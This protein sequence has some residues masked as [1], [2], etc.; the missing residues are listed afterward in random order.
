MFY[1]FLNKDDIKEITNKTKK[2]KK[3]TLAISTAA[4]AIPVNPKTAAMIAIN[5]KMIVHLSIY[6][7]LS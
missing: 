7:L 4:P 1:R 2:I 5:K 6:F 3:M